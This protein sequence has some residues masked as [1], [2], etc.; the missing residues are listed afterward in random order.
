MSVDLRIFAH[1]GMCKYLSG[2]VSADLYIKNID[3][4][5]DTACQ[6]ICFAGTSFRV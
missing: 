2:Y 6:K 5:L 4:V 3:L 1:I